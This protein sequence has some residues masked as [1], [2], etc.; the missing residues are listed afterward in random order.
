MHNLIS[1]TEKLRSA[2]DK[3]EFSCGVFLDLQKAF[4]TVDHEVL[5]D[6]LQHYGIRG[7]ANE[8]FRSFLTG[9]KQFVFISDFKSNTKEIKFGVPQGSVLGPLLFIIYINDLP[10]AL[11]YSD[12]F[13]FADDTAIVYSNAK[14]KSIKKRINIDLKLLMKWLNANKISLNVA[15][16]EVILFRHPNKQIDYN[17]RL[18]LNGKRLTFTTHVKYLGVIL[19]EN[20]SWKFHINSISTKLRKS[21]GIISRLRYYLPKSILISLYYALFHSHVSYSLQVWGQNLS[22]NS[23][24]IKLQKSAVRLITF[25]NF[26]AHSKPLFRS[27]SIP[28][29]TELTF[30]LNIYLVHK[31]L[32]S[33]TPDDIVNTLQLTYLPNNYNTRAHS[34]KL[35]SRFYIKTACFG[36]NSIRYKS[37]LAWNDLQTYYKNIDL[38]L[39]SFPKLKT[40]T[41]KFINL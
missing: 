29:I 18:K 1:L 21:N 4:D 35:L 27:L 26:N 20:L 38:A 37:I 6:K 24:P 34:C 31:S 19:D 12:P 16:T 36:Y 32:N 10:N 33:H 40:L 14:L 25:E 9:R 5:L 11:I 23:R 22:N 28:P 30:L 41:R 2:L 39:V 8:W 7:V 17:V 15:K 13:I 3:G